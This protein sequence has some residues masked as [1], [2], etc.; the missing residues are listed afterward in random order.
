MEVLYPRTNKRRS[1]L[2]YSE[3]D[4]CSVQTYR[5][6]G[7]E[8]PGL[9]MVHFRHFDSNTLVSDRTE[10]KCPEL[11]H[12]LLFAYKQGIFRELM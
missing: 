12:A 11:V 10:N 1:D 5:I 3:K 8:K 6:Q 9:I 7:D 4:V 2:E